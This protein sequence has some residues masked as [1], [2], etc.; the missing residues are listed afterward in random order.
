MRLI[1]GLCLLLV[2][3]FLG[4][5]RRRLPASLARLVMRMELPLAI[6]VR[7]RGGGMN[8]AADSYTQENGTAYGP[9]LAERLVTYPC[10]SLKARLV[11]VPLI[12]FL[13]NEAVRTRVREYA[14]HCGEPEFRTEMETVL[15]ESKKW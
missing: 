10:G 8:D 13:T 14:A 11:W 7:W 12:F 5:I 4:A 15:E 3:L 9:A 2:L 6:H 1:Y